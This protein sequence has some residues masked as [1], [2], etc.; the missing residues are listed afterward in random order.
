ME[1]RVT[2]RDKE[3]EENEMGLESRERCGQIDMIRQKG[4]GGREGSYLATCTSSII[5]DD[6]IIL[7]G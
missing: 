4:N 2:V 6:N 1:E 3:G 5:S 7:K